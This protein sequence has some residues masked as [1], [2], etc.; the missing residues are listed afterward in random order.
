MSSWTSSATYFSNAS[1]TALASDAPTCQFWVSGGVYPVEGPFHFA[2]RNKNPPWCPFNHIKR[3]DRMSTFMLLLSGRYCI[4]NFML[5]KVLHGQPF[6]YLTIWKGPFTW[7]HKSWR[8]I[9]ACWVVC[10]QSCWEAL[11]VLE[12]FLERIAENKSLVQDHEYHQDA[13][14]TPSRRKVHFPVFESA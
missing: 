9:L 6:L 3:E 1:S 2:Q 4:F 8:P 11:L 12:E 7:I 14:P 5:M 10:S 13:C